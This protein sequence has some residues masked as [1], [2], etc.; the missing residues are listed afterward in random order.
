MRF[1]YNGQEFRIWFQ[2]KTTGRLRYTWC[3][4][5]RMDGPKEATE[6]ISEDA[7]CSNSDNFC[8]AVGRKLS[9]A[10][11]LRKL[12][13]DREYRRVAW[14]AYHNRA[15]QINKTWEPSII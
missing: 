14:M 15:I 11:A 8:R 6:L 1:T 9:L 10:R 13:P 4:I 12:T 5:A 2:H 3:T 7:Y